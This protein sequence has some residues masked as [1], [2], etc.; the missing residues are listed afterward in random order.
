MKARLPRTPDGCRL[1]SR[2]HTAPLCPILRRASVP[3]P[4]LCRLG[5]PYLPG[6]RE[7]IF[8]VGV[9]LLRIRLRQGVRVPAPGPIEPTPPHLRS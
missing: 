8:C 9:P 1:G 4:R 2:F 3:T 6:E 5:V 7:G